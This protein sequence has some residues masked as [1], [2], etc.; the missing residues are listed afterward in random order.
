MS[1]PGAPQRRIWV[2][3]RLVR[4]EQATVH[5]LSQSLQR[6]S[7]IF[8]YMSVHPTSRGPAVFRLPDHVARFQR[9]LSL[10]GL[11]LSMD[12]SQLRDAIVETVRANPGATAVKLSAYLPSVEVDVVPI[13][14]RVEVAIAAYD[15][16]SDVVA[17]KPNPPVPSPELRIRLERER[18]KVPAEAIPPQA[19]VA[20]NYL[21]PMIAKWSA[22]R[23]GYDEVLLVDLSGHLAEGPTTNVFLV[24]R[25]GRLLTPPAG[26]ILEGITRSSVLEIAKHDGRAVREEPLAPEALFEASEVFLTG[27]TAGVWPVVAIDGRPIGNGRAGAVATELRGRLAEVTSG[28]DPAF[29]HWLTRVDEG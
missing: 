6:G 13:D 4:W 22:R 26:S 25:A 21:G 7:L 28:R 29:E 27:T 10:V 3:G 18:L 12:A 1:D 11:P 16:Q 9:S 19:K 17:R 5:V 23:A 15:P 24:D 8:D 20:G 14:D 2:D